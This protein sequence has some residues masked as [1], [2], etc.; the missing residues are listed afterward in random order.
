V[1]TN[2][3]AHIS[4]TPAPYRIIRESGHRA[5]PAEST[6][7]PSTNMSPEQVRVAPSVDKYSDVYSLGVVLYEM[8]TGSRPFEGD[9]PFS[10]MQAHV[11]QPPTPPLEVDPGLPPA[12]NEILLTALAKE[13]GRRYSSA[14]AFRDAIEN[15]H[16]RLSWTA[17]LVRK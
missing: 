2:I 6:M 9:N 16:G 4:T 5:A 17:P 13:P 10:L 15:L 8:A 14:S 12:L 1:A 3:V 7:L 11:E